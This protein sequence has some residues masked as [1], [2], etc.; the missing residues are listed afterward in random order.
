[1]SSWI[2][3]TT[4]NGIEYGGSHDFYWWDINYNPG[5]VF[6]SNLGT[7]DLALP[8][9]T[10][11]CYGRIQEAGDPIPVSRFAN[12]NNWHNYLTNGWTYVSFNINNV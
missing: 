9:C 5:A 12:A 3:R 7:Y 8:N 4:Y 11:Y 10:T 6:D 1:M 2:P